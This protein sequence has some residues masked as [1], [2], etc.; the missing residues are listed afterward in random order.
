M[1]V[2]NMTK[3]TI[4]STW[5]AGLVVLAAGLAL[6]GISLGLMLAYGGTFTAAPSGNGYDF[7]PRFDN[8]FSTT[9]GFLVL[10][11]T[12]AV[13][14]GI[15]QLAA[16]VGA[17]INTNRIAD[18]TWFSVLLIGGL[19]GLALAPVGFAAMVAYLVAGPDGMLVQ[20]QPATPGR[21]HA[22]L[23]PTT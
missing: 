15:V 16:W 5:V 21:P 6:A 4:T 7:V 9:V 3:P 10:G 14:G 13:V 20:Q 8:V 22:T 23:A 1:E 2:N 11:F 18:K 17:L 12:V 19:L